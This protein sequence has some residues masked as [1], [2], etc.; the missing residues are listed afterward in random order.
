MEGM[1]ERLEKLVRAGEIRMLGYVSQEELPA[2]Y[3]GAAAFA[4][5]S[6]YEGFGLPVL[7]AL[8]SG[9][10]VVTS[11]RSSLVEVAGDA[12]IMVEPEDHAAIRAALQGL[13][14]PSTERQQRVER[15]ISWARTFT[16]ERCAEKTVAVYRAA[17]A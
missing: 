9:V 16:W 7:E 2:L 17:L 3:A 11:N 15:G 1:Q 4:Y 13:L 12:A 14:E 8:A 6:M 10:P 5:P